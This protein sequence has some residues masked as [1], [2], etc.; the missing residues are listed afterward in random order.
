M[1]S[2]LSTR[3]G[4]CGP[5]SHVLKRDLSRDCMQLLEL[6]QRINFGRIEGLRV[7]NGEPVLSSIKSAR[8]VHKLKGE[9]GPRPELEIVDFSLKQEVCEFFRLIKRVGNGELDLIEIKHGLPFIVEINE[10]PA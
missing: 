6:M 3:G 1:D 5:T 2:A 7:V 8:S 4:E 9:N 10:V